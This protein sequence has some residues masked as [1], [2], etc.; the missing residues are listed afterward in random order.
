[1]FD[2]AVR[3]FPGSTFGVRYLGVT[4]NR[5]HPQALAPVEPIR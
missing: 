1:M 2:H 3:V 5:L 4:E